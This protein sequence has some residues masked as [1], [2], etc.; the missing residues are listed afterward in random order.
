MDFYF[1][2]HQPRMEGTTGREAQLDCFEDACVRGKLKVVQELCDHYPD[3]VRTVFDF[4]HQEEWWYRGRGTGLHL[5]ARND[6]PACC[7]ALLDAGA[8]IDAIDGNERTPL[9]FAEHFDVLTLL[10]CRGAKVNARDVWKWTALHHC[11]FY[12]GWDKRAAR[13][14]VSRGADIHAVGSDGWSPLMEIMLE[15]ERQS[16]RTFHRPAVG[17]EMV[18]HE[19]S[20]TPDEDDRTLLHFLASQRGHEDVVRDIES[21]VKGGADMEAKD[22]LGHSPLFTAALHNNHTACRKL[23]ELGANV[24]SEMCNSDEDS[25]LLL[26]MRHGHV[27]AAC[28]IINASLGSI[29]ACDTDG[30][31]ALLLAA[32]NGCVQTSCELIKARASL[33]V[34]N[35]DGDTALILAAKNGHTQ[36]ACMLIKIGASSEA[37]NG[38]GDAAIHV[39]VRNRFFETACE[40]IRVGV[41]AETR[42]EAGETALLITAQLEHSAEG[43]HALV[44]AGSNV[45]A[46]DNGG[47]SALI[48]A[49]KNCHVAAAEVLIPAGANAQLSSRSGDTA[50]DLAAKMDHTQIA[51]QLVR[52]GAN[53]SLRNSDGDT[54]L[55]VVSKRDNGRL[56]CELIRHGAK[57]DGP[58]SFFQPLLCAVE[59]GDIDMLARLVDAGA[60]VNLRGV[61]GQSILYKAVCC[62]QR[63]AVK[64]LIDNGA[65]ISS[66]LSIGAAHQHFSDEDIRDKAKIDT[67]QSI[68]RCSALKPLQPDLV[69]G[70]I[71][72]GMPDYDKH[73]LVPGRLRPAKHM[74]PLRI[75]VLGPPAVGKTALTEHLH[76]RFT[77]CSDEWR[78]DGQQNAPCTSTGTSTH[79]VTQ[80]QFSIHDFG[81]HADFLA[82]HPF[83]IGDM[84]IPMI[85]VIVVSVLDPLREEKIFNWCS[86]YAHANRR[87]HANTAILVVGTHADESTADQRRTMV[88]VYNKA[89]RMFGNYFRFPLSKPLLVDARHMQQD[90]SIKLQRTLHELYDELV[91]RD[92]SPWESTMHTCQAITRH[93][94]AAQNT[95]RTPVVTKAKFVE[96][97]RPHIPVPAAGEESSQ[98]S[99]TAASSL[100]DEALGASG[101]ECSALSFPQ[102][103]AKD[104]VVIDPQRLLSQIIDRLM[105][106]TGS[107]TSVDSHGGVV[108]KKDLVEALETEY[109]PGHAALEMLTHLGL[110]LELPDGQDVL[111]PSMLNENL[112][113]VHWLPKPSMTVSRGRCLQCQGALP[114]ADTIFRQVQVEVGRRYLAEYEGRVPIWKN[115]LRIAV[116]DS[117]VEALVELRNDRHCIDVVVR[118]MRG[119]EQEC[120]DL[121][122]RLVDDVQ[123]KAS[124]V[125]PASLLKVSNLSESDL[126]EVC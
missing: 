27:K 114:F 29:D 109:L 7:Q 78:T 73:G 102:P 13:E 53:T 98:L 106:V 1:F 44:E 112:H 116:N 72:R 110:C 42:N 122:D 18:E 47:N 54:V 55:S 4:K 92:Q 25:A 63:S 61:D 28:E 45:N 88:G 124:E 40:L 39:A 32:Q 104:Y 11:V 85:N 118:G 67:N 60:S 46:V 82:T 51:C 94:Q 3:L 26:A 89:R 19:R 16:A 79:L 103:T 15:T 64:W 75:R 22:R 48:L 24:V 2:V 93:R 21:L 95:F 35:K 34:R 86:V 126:R 6:H 87:E 56:F 125:Y 77:D 90:L 5:A 81:G 33:E 59:D 12:S 120:A 62:Q 83:L 76:S 43:I 84:T 101:S 17:L 66:V 58:V 31:T 123:R 10:L 30:N 74:H 68:V 36:I 23:I 71:P 96:F 107:R 105:A 20:E 117:Q 115:G 100:I 70:K 49:L 111:N 41:D 52:A 37:H 99:E 121:L 38:N 8:D 119:F 69:Y 50:L 9:F 80:T 97:M 91:V 108:R 57:P 113:G 14:L 65:N